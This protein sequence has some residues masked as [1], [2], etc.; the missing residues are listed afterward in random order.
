APEL[1]L[2]R[3]IADCVEFYRVY[4]RERLHQIWL[5]VKAYQRKLAALSV[6][7]GAVRDLG[8]AHGG[9]ELTMV[10]LLGALPAAAGALLHSAPYPLN[11]VLG[12]LFASADPTRIA[13][14]R[15]ATGLVLFPA[16]Y[17]LYGWLLWRHAHW[18]AGAI[19]AVLVACLPLG[20]FA[21][22]YF[23]WL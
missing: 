16:T 18:T 1:A 7:D 21:D 23:R 2:S 22:A 20:L 5:A 13:F 9:T 4:D 6:D 10:A 8:T 15:I 3:S 19:V 17:A 14:S 12:T 11:A